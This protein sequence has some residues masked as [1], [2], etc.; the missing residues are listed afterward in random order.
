MARRNPFVLG[1]VTLTGASVLV[2]LV[3][4]I[5]WMHLARN[6][7]AANACINNLRQLDSALPQW[8]LEHDKKDEDAPDPVAVLHYFKG[9][10]LPDCPH[11]GTYSLG[12]TLLEGPRCSILKDNFDGQQLW[13]VD[14]SGKGIPGASIA[15]GTNRYETDT[16]GVVATPAKFG[17]RE[18]GIQA[19]VSKPEF[20]TSVV[21][22]PVS[23]GFKIKLMPQTNVPP[24]TT[25]APIK[26]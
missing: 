21:E 3:Q 26:R 18:R 16:Y 7:S 12:K 13:V 5:R 9:G 25:S 14:Q 19:T 15:I 4:G 24:A 1:I 17:I 8:A 2:L 23:G 20:Q 6:V 11:G 10:R 22:L